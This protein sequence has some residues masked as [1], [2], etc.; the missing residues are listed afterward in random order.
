MCLVDGFKVSG[1]VSL[2]GSSMLSTSILDANAKVT[3][4]ASSLLYNSLALGSVK[5]VKS[6]N[7][8]ASGTLPSPDGSAANRSSVT[9][10]N[11]YV[12]DDYWKYQLDETDNANINANTDASKTQEYCL[13]LPPP[14]W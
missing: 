8:T 2:Q 1:N 11:K 14:Y 6:V 9:T 10:Y 13:Y 5:D 3:G 4:D 12:K 7:V